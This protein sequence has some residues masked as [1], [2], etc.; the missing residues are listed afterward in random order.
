ML[1]EFIRAGQAGKEE[2][3]Q[4]IRLTNATVSSIRMHVNEAQAGGP[5]DNRALADVS[6][7]FQRIEVEHKTG[8]TM[9]VDDWMAR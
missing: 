3:Y 1:V 9:A 2:V 8:R 6:F 4:T 5:G 7:T